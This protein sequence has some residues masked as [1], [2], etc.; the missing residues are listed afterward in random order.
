[1]SNPE[2]IF[3]GMA[4]HAGQC[5]DLDQINLNRSESFFI[6]EDS[7]EGFSTDELTKPAVHGLNCFGIDPNE[8]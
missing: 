7:Q 4:R 6:D 8:F 5:I 1:M 2:Y 3:K